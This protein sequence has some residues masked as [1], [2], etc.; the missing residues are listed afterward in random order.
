ML[1]IHNAK[2]TI[3]LKPEEYIGHNELIQKIHEL[4]HKLVPIDFEKEK[5]AIQEE[6]VESFENRKIKIYSLEIKK[7]MHTKTFI[8]TLKE[9]LREEQCMQILEQKWSRL[10]DD[11]FFYIRLDKDAALK[12]IFELTDS[13]DCI[14][15]KMHIAAFPKN[16]EVALKIVTEIF[17]SVSR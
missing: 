12:D 2:I 14:H 11:L 17:D 16:R 3:F 10:D 9:L 8:K 5:V 13:G 1:F 15:I 4:F 6:I 7:E